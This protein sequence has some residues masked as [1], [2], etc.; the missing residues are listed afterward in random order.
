MY[1][2]SNKV[3]KNYTKRFL[4]LGALHEDKVCDILQAMAPTNVQTVHQTSFSISRATSID[5]NCCCLPTASGLSNKADKS[6]SNQFRPANLSFSRP[7]HH[8]RIRRIEIPRPMVVEA[9]RCEAGAR[10]SIQPSRALC[11]PRKRPTNIARSPLPVC[12]RRKKTE[13]GQSLAFPSETFR[14]APLI[15]AHRVSALP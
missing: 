12:P 10:A 2:P 3:I 13:R 5:S 8:A 6:R 1:C 15:L 9:L 7:Y 11:I 14:F 4:A